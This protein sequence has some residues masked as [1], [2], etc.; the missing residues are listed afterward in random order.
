MSPT[1]ASGPASANPNPAMKSFAYTA[2]RLTRSANPPPVSPLLPDC[3]FLRVLGNSPSTAQ[4]FLA[5]ETHL[6]AGHLTPRERELIALAVAEMNG[7]E[8]GLSAHYAVAKS[9]GISQDEILLARKATSS[10]P[11]MTAILHFTRAVTLQRGEVSD[12]EF[13]NLRKAGVTDPQIVEIIANICTNIFTNYFTSVART[14]VDFPLLKP[15]F[16]TPIGR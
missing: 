2:P 15:G 13:Q 9:L 5:N 10:D 3:N 14:E 11:R 7:S 4:A 8:Y 6:A 12:T 16:E 1:I